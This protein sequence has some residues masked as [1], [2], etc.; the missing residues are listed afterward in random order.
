M[1]KLLTL[2]VI[3][4][5]LIAFA[6]SALSA[7]QG[8]N[9]TGSL[10][11]IG[12]ALR[13]DNADVYTRIVDLAGGKGAKIAIIPTASGNPMKNGQRQADVFKEY[14]VEPFVVP[15]GAV[16]RMN[17]YETEAYNEELVQQIRECTAVY[18]IGGDQERIIKALYDKEGKRTPVLQAVWDVYNKGGVIAGSSAGA[19]IMSEV[20]FRDGEV[21]DVLKR[22]K[23]L[24]VA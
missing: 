23:R 15:I 12:G 18:F 7:D 1:R 11:I 10:V 5:N 16:K 9:K 13:N 4:L 19:A 20:M 3:I 14:G 6:G 17:N 2:V 8:A 24:T 21:L 22:V